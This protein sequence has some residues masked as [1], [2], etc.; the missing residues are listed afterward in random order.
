MISTLETGYFIWNFSAWL[1]IFLLSACA[2][3]LLTFI[4][5]KSTGG[6][7]VSNNMAR[8]CE[9]DIEEGFFE[10]I[11]SSFR[12]R[13]MKPWFDFPFSHILSILVLFLLFAV[14]LFSKSGVE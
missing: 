2:F 13:I 12:S 10:K 11:V 8:G 5:K 14:A 7:L 9:R 4:I 3:C 6:S 1:K